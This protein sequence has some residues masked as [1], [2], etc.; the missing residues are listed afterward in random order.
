M[1]WAGIIAWALGG[2]IAILETIPVITIFSPALD[3]VIISFVSYLIFYKL[4]EKTSLVGQ[5]DMTIEEAT[6]AAR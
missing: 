2:G 1:N 6:A 4:F 5:G 3:G